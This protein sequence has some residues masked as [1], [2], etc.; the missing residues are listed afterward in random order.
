VAN[1]SEMM[2]ALAEPIRQT[3]FDRL[4]DGPR[5][6]GELAAD[7]PISRP[8]VSQHLKVLKDVGL[9]TDRKAGTRRLY[10]VDPAGLA[11]LR[12]YL[13]GMWQRSLASFEQAVRD[14]DA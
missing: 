2:S 10:S 6:V 14:A 7:L 13:D 5:P 9:V 1:P 11:I 4:A 3:I 8:A 12:S